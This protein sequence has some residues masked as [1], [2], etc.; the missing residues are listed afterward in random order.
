MGSMKYETTNLK[1]VSS[2]VKKLMSH[3]GAETLL[4]SMMASKG[5]YLLFF[6]QRHNTDHGLYVLAT[7]LAPVLAKV[8]ETLAGHP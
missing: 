7:E 8:Y 2:A 4:G 5:V 3:H 6:S 1:D